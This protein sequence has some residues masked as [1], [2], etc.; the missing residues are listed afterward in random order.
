MAIMSGSYQSVSPP[1]MVQV[2]F[3]PLLLFCG[4]MSHNHLVIMQMWSDCLHRSQK[5]WYMVQLSLVMEKDAE[6]L[7]L[8]LIAALYVAMSVGRSVGHPKIDE[9][10][11]FGSDFP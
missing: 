11:T 1:G 10:K 2:I 7:F 5:H 8:A 4:Q 3:P 6:F 9:F